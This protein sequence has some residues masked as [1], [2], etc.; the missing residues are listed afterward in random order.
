MRLRLNVLLE[1]QVSYCYL[2]PENEGLVEKYISYTKK[3]ELAF[4]SQ[5]G[6]ADTIY[7]VL[8]VVPLFECNKKGIGH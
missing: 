2:K 5:A 7:T 6:R 1:L 4:L 8:L 3:K